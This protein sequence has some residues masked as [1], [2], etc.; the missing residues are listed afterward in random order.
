M[1]PET[2]IEKGGLEHLE[3]I[4]HFNYEI[5]EGMYEDKPYSLEQYQD[6]LKDKELVIFIAKKDGQLAG[7][8]I[9]F[10]KDKSFYIWILGVS[11]KHRGEGIGSAL[12]SKNEQFAQ[13]NDFESVSVKVYNVSAAMQQLLK[14]RGYSIV[15]T[16]ESKKDPKYTALF[17][18]LKLDK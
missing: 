14:N 8:S 18:E 17:F 3:Q 10:K 16:E 12:L 15:K 5:F 13:E 2:V 4:V 11:E 6:K 7:D 9:S 1:H